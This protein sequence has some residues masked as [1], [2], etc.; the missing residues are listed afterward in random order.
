MEQIIGDTVMSMWMV[1]SRVI[2]LCRRKLKIFS[3]LASNPQHII[4]QKEQNNDSQSLIRM[5]IEKRYALLR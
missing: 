5:A 2:S 3:Y 1:G 4:L